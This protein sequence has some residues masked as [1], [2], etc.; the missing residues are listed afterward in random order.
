MKC[1]YTIGFR[2]IKTVIAVFVCLLIKLIFQRET[3]LYAAIAAVICMQ[4]TPKKS[5]STGIHRFNG[6]IIG[7]IIGFIVL[8][9][10]PYIPSYYTFSYVLIIPIGM[11]ASMYVCTLIKQNSSIAICCIVFLSIVTNFGRDIVNTETYVII[12][13]IDTTIGIVVA[14]IINKYF[15]P[16]GQDCHEISTE[17][18]K[19][20]EQA[21]NEANSEKTG[22]PKE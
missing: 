6:T 9:L 14:T 16:Y 21:I 1:R 18:T 5:I 20:D 8:K 13:I 4:Q 22:L 7:A 3:V 2:T 17:E 12:R 10:V 11:L 15:F 19:I